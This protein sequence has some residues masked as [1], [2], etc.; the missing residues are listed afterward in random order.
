MSELTRKQEQDVCRQAIVNYVADRAEV[1][2][3][4]VAQHVTAITGWS[5]GPIAA[6]RVLGNLGWVRYILPIGNPQRR[7]KIF[8]RF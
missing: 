6:A 2:A 3:T 7:V 5:Y 4:E 1:R 8:R